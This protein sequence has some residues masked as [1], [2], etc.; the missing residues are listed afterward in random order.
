MKPL[1][2][3]LVVVAAV[4]GI[5]AV[6]AGLLPTDTQRVFVVVDASFAMRPVWDQVDD[7]LDRIDSREDAEFAL[8]TEK[9][10]IHTWSDQLRLGAI[11]PFA[12][13]TFAGI[14]NHAEVAEADTLILITTAAS[15]DTT[16]LTDW[17]I[18]LLQP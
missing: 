13:C 10:F 14:E 4:F 11:S 3:W 5:L 1:A 7:E 15:C 12:P 17:D 16:A 8:A 2:I 18:R 6:I 9:D